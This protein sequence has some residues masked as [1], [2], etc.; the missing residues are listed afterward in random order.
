[1][2]HRFVIF[3]RFFII[4]YSKSHKFSD[5]LRL[6][7]TI[8][9]KSSVPKSLHTQSRHHATAAYRCIAFNVLHLSIFIEQGIVRDSGERL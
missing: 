4:I 2:H 6:D 8:H 9:V 5:M 1:M 7:Q 3:H